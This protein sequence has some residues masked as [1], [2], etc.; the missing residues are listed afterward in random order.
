MTRKGRLAVIER[1]QTSLSIPADYTRIR[2]KENGGAGFRS[3]NHQMTQMH[4]FV[5]IKAD[6]LLYIY[7]SP[8]SIKLI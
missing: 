7:V 8:E 1:D 5:G 4:V 2:I 6:V 3:I